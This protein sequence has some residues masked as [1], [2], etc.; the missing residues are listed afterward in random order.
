MRILRM[1]EVQA[2]VGL[3]RSS[4]YER[5]DE[6][7]PRYDATF[8]RPVSLGAA[9]VGW[10]ESEIDEWIAARVRASRAQEVA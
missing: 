4:I 3:G 5:I 9:A 1:R 2:K 8:P 10:I 7:H 6:K